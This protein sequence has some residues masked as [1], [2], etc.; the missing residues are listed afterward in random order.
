M[1]KSRNGCSSYRE[2]N[3]LKH[4]PAYS[5]G[6]AEAPTVARR[7]KT[8]EDQIPEASD[9]AQESGLCLTHQAS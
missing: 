1:G 4:E 9:H 7:D 3:D 5:L 8:D 6:G 2:E